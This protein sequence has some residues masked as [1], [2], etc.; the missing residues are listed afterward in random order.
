MNPPKIRLK[1]IDLSKAVKHECPGIR[2]ER[3]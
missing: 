3:T 1:K 2:T